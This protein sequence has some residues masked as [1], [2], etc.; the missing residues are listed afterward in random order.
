MDK[1]HTD[2]GWKDA[3]QVH[4]YVERAIQRDQERLPQMEM[5]SRLLPFWPTDAFQFLDLG[6]GHGNLSRVV[7]ERFPRSTAVLLDTSEAMLEAAASYL[8]EFGR[9]VS[10]LRCDFSS[11]L[12]PGTYTGSF[13]AIISS[14]A[15]H[16]LKA[17]ADEARLYRSA[18]VALAPGGGFLNLDL[19]APPTPDLDPVYDQ[20]DRSW[21]KPF[22]ES[23]RS[24]VRPLDT[25]LTLLRNSGFA[26]VDC[27][28]KSLH[29]ALY[30]GFKAAAPA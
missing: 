11:E 20:A 8:G 25:H 23:P 17:Q 18:F 15:V 29:E 7:L 14:L 1:H 19:V 5:L 22:F 27:F 10:F 16:H 30:G 4:E 21:L 2:H 3:S 12:I 26:E 13:G 24:D 6:A 28:W 9:R